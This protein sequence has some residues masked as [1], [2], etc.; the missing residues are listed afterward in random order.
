MVKFQHV[1]PSSF[2]DVGE[3][4]HVY[5]ADPEP[6]WFQGKV[7][8]VCSRSV[9]RDGGYVQCE[10][11]YEDDNTDTNKLHDAD[12]CNNDRKESWRFS[13]STSRVIKELESLNIKVEPVQ[14]RKNVVMI[15]LLSAAFI[16]VA[17]T[18]GCMSYCKHDPTEPYVCPYIAPMENVMLASLRTLRE[19]WLPRMPL[20]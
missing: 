8:K 15:S 19:S 7:T 5:Y 20:L 6:K 14:T 4:V 16:T 18:L 9:D 11:K 3:H 2:V 17:A 13:W 1:S 10:I 12:F